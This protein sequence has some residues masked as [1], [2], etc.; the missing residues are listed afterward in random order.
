[1]LLIEIDKNRYRRHFN[2]V[3][4]ACIVF[5]VVSSLI[6]SQSLIYFFPAQEGTHFHWNLIGVVISVLIAGVVIKT[7]RAHPFLHEVLFVW[8]LKQA[9]NLIARK[10]NKL[11]QAAKMGDKN[12]LLALQFSYTGSRKL[13][14]LDD[15]TITLNNLDK[16]QRELDEL[17][18]KY[19]INLDLNQYNSE[20]LK[21]F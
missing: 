8:Q 15:N 18:I 4:A 17:L 6:I 13:W 19:D 7:N 14:L 11:Q 21:S 5:L 12:A 10:I 1:M 3:I 16:C 20:L 2:M 9:L